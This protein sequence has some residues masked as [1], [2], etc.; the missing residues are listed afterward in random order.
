MNPASRPTTVQPFCEHIVSRGIL[1]ERMAG[2]RC[3]GCRSSISQGQFRI[4]CQLLGFL[5]YGI[6][7]LSCVLFLSAF[8]SF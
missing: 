3:C 2:K 6:C 1:T 4:V 8:V 5:F 7:V